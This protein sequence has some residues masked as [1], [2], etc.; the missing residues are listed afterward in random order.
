MKRPRGV[1][2]DI[3]VKVDTFYYPIDF[4]VIDMKPTNPAKKQIPVLLGQPFLA[5][6]NACIQCR[7]GIMDISFGNMQLQLNVFRTSQHPSFDIQCKY[8]DMIDDGVEEVVPSTLLRDSFE[9]N[10]QFDRP[11]I[12]GLEDPVPAHPS[13]EAPPS[14]E[15]K[16]LLASL[17]YVFLGPHET[18]PVNNSSSSTSSQESQLIHVLE[19]YMSHRV[20]AVHL[21]DQEKTIFTCP[22][23]TF[24]YRRM[25]SE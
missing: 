1:I 12:L 19:K 17:K 6:T 20:V 5:T 9:A 11:P 23:G 13:I 25:P 7:T 4:V 24:A 15:L 14:L 21:D 2:E 3:L 8:M 22:F 10:L 16:P 18:L